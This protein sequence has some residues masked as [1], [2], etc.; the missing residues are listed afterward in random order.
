MTVAGP[1]ETKLGAKT[2]GPSDGV[3]NVIHSEST[4]FR[5]I[6]GPRGNI[7]PLRIGTRPNVEASAWP[8]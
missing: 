1:S 5:E 8:D 2:T 7:A 3:C 6:G 4:K